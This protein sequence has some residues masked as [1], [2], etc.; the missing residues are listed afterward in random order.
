MGRRPRLLQRLE[1]NFRLGIAL[2]LAGVR[3]RVVGGAYLEHADVARVA[4]SA[5]LQLREAREREPA[6]GECELRGAVRLVTALGWGVEL[7]AHVE[8]RLAVEALQRGALLGHLEV[9]DWDLLVA[10]FVDRHAELARLAGRVRLRRELA[11]A[12]VVVVR[13]GVA[14]APDVDLDLEQALGRGAGRPRVQ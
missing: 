2:R 5:E 8:Q 6:R 3:R 14:A 1:Q 9:G 13:G 12:A 10:L 4:Q 7:L 11:L